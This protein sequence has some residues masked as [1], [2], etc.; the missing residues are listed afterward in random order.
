MLNLSNILPNVGL[1]KTAMKIAEYICPERKKAN[2]NLTRNTVTWRIEEINCILR[3]VVF[4]LANL[5]LLQ[6]KNDNIKWKN[7]HMFLLFEGLLAL[8]QF[9]FIKSGPPLEKFGHPWFT[10]KKTWR[11]RLHFRFCDLFVPFI[12]SVSSTQWKT[13]AIYEPCIVS[14][15]ANHLRS[16]WIWSIVHHVVF[17]ARNVVYRIN[18]PFKNACNFWPSACV[19]RLLIH[20]MTLI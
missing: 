17:Q 6:Y 3:S 19:F 12:C 9:H 2:V 20:T 7:I 13:S 4:K 15:A 5:V 18:A 10:G 8:G 11:K 1:Q 16:S 14:M